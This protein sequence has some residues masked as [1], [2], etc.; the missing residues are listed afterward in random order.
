MATSDLDALPDTVDAMIA[1]RIDSWRPPR[2]TGCEAHRCSACHSTSQ[3]SASMVGES[4]LDDLVEF[5]D[6]VDGHAR[7]RQALYQQ[8]AYDGLPFRRRRVLHGAVARLLEAQGSEPN[9]GQLSLHFFQA[10]DYEPA[11][12]YALSAG[13]SAEERFAFT[14]GHEGHE[15]VVGTAGEAPDHVQLVDGP[16]AVDNVTV[17]DENKVIWLSQTTL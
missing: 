14:V 5:I 10:Q 7:F 2:E 13:K 1:A 16:D 17:R 15:E 8:A 11:W 3:R 6:V 4:N 12:T 9:A